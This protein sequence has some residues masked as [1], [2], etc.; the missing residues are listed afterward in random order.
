M[1]HEYDFT[2]VLAGVFFICVAAVCF[3][4]AARIGNRE[5]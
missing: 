4:W 1:T 2:I 5:T 3:A